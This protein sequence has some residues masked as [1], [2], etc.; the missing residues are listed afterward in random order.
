M[1][2]Q[3]RLGAV[4]EYVFGEGDGVGEDKI[5]VFRPAIIVNNWG[6]LEPGMV[7]LQVLVDGSNDTA[8]GSNLWKTSVEYDGKKFSPGT[9]HFPSSDQILHKT[10]GLKA[11]SRK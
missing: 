9:W 11:K 8:D 4:V 7:N 3:A 1:S 10:P 2:Q 6:S 5:G